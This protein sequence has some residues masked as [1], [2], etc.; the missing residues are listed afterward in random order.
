MPIT[1]EEFLRQSMEVGAFSALARNV[2]N[3]NIRKDKADDIADA[4]FDFFIGKFEEAEKEAHHISAVLTRLKA[5]ARSGKTP[6]PG[7]SWTP[8]QSVIDA[9]VRELATLHNWLVSLYETDITILDT[10]DPKLTELQ[11]QKMAD[12]MNKV[13][14]ERRKRLEHGAHFAKFFYE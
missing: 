9:F 7:Q 11:P 2:D 5:S 14:A 4:I 3:G 12:A 13:R 1:K 8:K 6:A 10:I